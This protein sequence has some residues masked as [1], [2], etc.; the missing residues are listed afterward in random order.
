MVMKYSK[1]SKLVNKTSINLSECNKKDFP[2]YEKAS[3]KAKN[4]YDQIMRK[5]YLCPNLDEKLVL[6]GSSIEQNLTYFQILVYPCQNSTDGGICKSQEEIDNSIWNKHLYLSFYYPLLSVSLNDYYNPFSYGYKEDF[7]YLPKTN[8]YRF[9][10]YGIELVSINTDWGFLKPDYRYEKEYTFAFINSDTRNIRV[11]DP[12]FL[13]IDILS[14]FTQNYYSRSYIKITDILSNCGGMFNAIVLFFVVLNSFFFEL[15]MTKLMINKLFMFK[16]PA[17]PL[18]N[19]YNTCRVYNR[20]L[21]EYDDIKRRNKKEK[22]FKKEELHEEKFNTDFPLLSKNKDKFINR[23]NSTTTKN[24]KNIEGKKKNFG[25]EIIYELETEKRN[26]ISADDTNYNA[27]KNNKYNNSK[28]NAKK[29]AEL[30]V[31]AVESSKKDLLQ[32]RRIK[33][34]Y[35]QNETSDKFTK[36]RDASL[37]SFSNTIGIKDLKYSNSKDDLEK[38]KLNEHDNNV[39]SELVKQGSKAKKSKTFKTMKAVEAIEAIKAEAR[40][41]ISSINNTELRADKSKKQSRNDAIRKSNSNEKSRSAATPKRSNNKNNTQSKEHKTIQ[42]LKLQFDSAATKF[43]N[44]NKHLAELPIPNI[45]DPLFNED[46][47]HKRYFI[48]LSKSRSK[49]DTL[50]LSVCKQFKLN[51]CGCFYKKKNPKKG[52][53]SQLYHLFDVYRKR[54]EAYFDYMKLIN[55]YHETDFLREILLEEHQKNILE[56]TKLKTIEI[57]PNFDGSHESSFNDSVNPESIIISGGNKVAAVTI[58]ASI[59]SL[60]KK[61]NKEKRYLKKKQSVIKVNHNLVNYL[62]R[63]K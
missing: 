45:N 7:Y 61:Y 56:I 27:Q 4:L 17:K 11:E 39:Y 29:A 60:F 58:E 57:P 16:D 22:D 54:I 59:D 1:N 20:F 42:Q 6:Y 37:P 46:E 51:F 8:N 25:Q 48:E 15:Q 18:N 14:T 47:Y 38:I 10:S 36:S 33:G 44:G 62:R 32:H 31:L 30:K 19:E 34:K 21:N 52:Y 28:S 55:N 24:N 5:R 2:D 23:I 63:L 41:N 53:D 50:T 49:R 13:S 35:S 26:F 43:K 40:A 3:N 9:F 12:Y